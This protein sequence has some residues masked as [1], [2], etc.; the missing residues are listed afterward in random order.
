MRRST[1]LIPQTLTRRPSFGGFGLSTLRF[2]DADSLSSFLSGAGLAIEEQLGDW[3]GQE[4]TD[5]S[6]EIITVARRA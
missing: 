2:L 6:P 3:D 4:L 5:T 1:F